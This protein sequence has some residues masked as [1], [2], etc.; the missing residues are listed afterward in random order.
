MGIE[1]GILECD[2]CNICGGDDIDVDDCGICFGNNY[3]MDCSGTCFGNAQEDDC[4]ICDSNSEN[5][6]ITCSGCTDINALNYNQNAIFND[7]SCQYNDRLFYVPLEYNTIQ[8]AIS[9][10]SDGDTV[11]VGPGTYYENI[12]FEIAIPDSPL[13]A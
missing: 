9:F 1:N 12:N 10:A 8:Q 13:T 2:S 3:N 11:E 7:N 5:D 6:N 4:G